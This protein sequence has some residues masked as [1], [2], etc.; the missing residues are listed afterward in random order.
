MIKHNNKQPTTQA[1]TIPAMAP[2]ESFPLSRFSLLMLAEV[3]SGM[4]GAVSELPSLE[5]PVGFVSEGGTVESLV[6]VA[7]GWMLDSTVSSSDVLGSGVSS[8]EDSTLFSEEVSTFSEVSG[9]LSEVDSTTFSEVSGVDSTVVSALD[10]SALELATGSSVEASEVTGDSTVS[11]EDSTL[12][13][14]DDSTPSEVS[15]T[16][17]EVDSDSMLDSTVV[18][19][20]SSVELDSSVASVLSE[21][22][23][24]SFETEVVSSTVDPHLQLYS[25]L[26]HWILQCPH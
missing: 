4:E 22:V 6:S 2:P 13:S 25:N 7:E 11:V 23:D 9:A 16:L 14:E 1:I 3:S 10:S 17:S 5:V 21:A 15:G 18:D 12:F 24:S 20:T 8:V 26:R 19:S